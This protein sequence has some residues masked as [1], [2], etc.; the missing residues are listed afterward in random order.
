M[1][2]FKIILIAL[3]ILIGIIFLSAAGLYYIE[4]KETKELTAADRKGTGGQY[5]Q[6]NEGVTHYQL[7]GP[8]TGKVVILMCPIIYGMVLMSF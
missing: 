4:N 1:R 3:L 2:I 7:A 6:L 5:I 8:D